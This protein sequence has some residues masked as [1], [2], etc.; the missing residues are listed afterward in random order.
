MRGLEEDTIV[1]A[2]PR[3]LP[4]LVSCLFNEFPPSRPSRLVANDEL[5][6][7]ISNLQIHVFSK[8]YLIIQV[9]KIFTDCKFLIVSRGYC[10]SFNMESFI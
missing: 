6:S 7:K 2:K 9:C 4:F 8:R 3:T 10:C 1:G 5:Y